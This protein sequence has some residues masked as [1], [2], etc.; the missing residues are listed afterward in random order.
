MTAGVGRIV[1]GIDVGETHIDAVLMQ[2][3]NVLAHKRITTTSGVTE[4]LKQ[5]I[6]DLFVNYQ[7]LKDKV[8][9]INIGATHLVNAL[10]QGQGFNKTLVVRLAFPLTDA[11]PSTIDW[12]QEEKER[13]GKYLVKQ[14]IIHGGYEF[15]AKDSS[16][17]PKE[18]SPLD[19]EEIRKL[20]QETRE[21]G[22]EAVAITGLFSTIN[23]LHDQEE[24]V[25]AIFK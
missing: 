25:R 5:V 1:I 8:H 14:L 11:F 17:K 12:D 16:S 20:A 3:R 2:E 23:D 9:S 21:N 13:L 15:Q 10:L 6:S 7:E 24:K 22:A 4:G 18:V 19:L